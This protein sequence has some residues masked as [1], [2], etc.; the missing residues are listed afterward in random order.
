MNA[1][2]AD[3]ITNI[4]TV[5]DCFGALAPEVRKFARIRRSELAAM[6]EDNPLVAL[7]QRNVRPGA[8]DLPLPTMGDL[9]PFATTFSEYFRPVRQTCPGKL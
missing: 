6:Y 4:M 7:W 8:N 5:H 2:V 1:A 3:G 9:N